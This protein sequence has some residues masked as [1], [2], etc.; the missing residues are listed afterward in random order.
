MSN[1]EETKVLWMPVCMIIVIGLGM[2]IGA[3]NGNLQA[4]IAVGVGFGLSIGVMIDRICARK[5]SGN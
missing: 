2:T 5:N 4:G 1:K 3:M